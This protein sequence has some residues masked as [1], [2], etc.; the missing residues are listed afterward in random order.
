MKRLCIVQPRLT[1]YRLSIFEEL[2]R[3]YNVDLVYSP[4]NGKDSFCN[5]QK[6]ISKKIRQYRFPLLKLFG[7]KFGLIQLGICKYMIREKPDIIILGT[8][9]RFLSFFQV[10]FFGKLLGIDIYAHGHGL[11]KKKQIN[12]LYRFMVK[13]ILKLVKGYICYAPIVKKSFLDFGFSDKKLFVAENSLVNNFQVRPEEKTGKE[14]GILFIGRLR[15]NSDFPLL[16]NVME[17]VRLETK[18]DLSLHVIGDGSE[19]KTLYEYSSQKSWI[20]LYGEIYDQL[21]IQKISQNCFLGCYPGNAGLSIVHMMSLSLPPITHN[22]IIAHQGPEPSYIENGINGLLFDYYE[23]Q[24]SLYEL[25]KKIIVSPKH[26]KD[27]QRAAFET[28]QSLTNPSLA[29]RLHSIIE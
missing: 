16:I 15:K 5:P 20:H 18:F 22:I 13:L 1:M 17:K 29:M 7:N 8:N 4:N 26:I 2:T 27:M 10:L 23:P 28:Y 3:Y 11:F 14:L 21:S 25:I 12:F 9:P 6:I 19:Q 24:K